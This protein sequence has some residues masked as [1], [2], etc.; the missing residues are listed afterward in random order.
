MHSDGTNN[1]HSAEMSF[2]ITKDDR[3]FSRLMAKETSTPNS[4]SRIFYYGETSITVP[5]MWEEQPGTPKHPLSDTSLPPLTRPPSYFSSS[6]S[7]NAKRRNLKT[8]VFSSILPRFGGPKKSHVSPPSSCSPSSSSSS[9]SSWSLADYSLPSFSM[10][11]KD[12]E[13]Q[14]S[15]SFSGSKSLFK[16]KR[17][18]GFRGCYPFGIGKKSTVSHGGD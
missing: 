10:R 4:S 5:F 17:A 1:N 11:D 2:R 7:N 8:N 16:Y 3:F 15:S 18:N 14:E 13:G 6:K 12:Q 9:S